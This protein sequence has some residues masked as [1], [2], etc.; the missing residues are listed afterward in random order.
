MA[1][2]PTGAMPLPEPGQ[3]VSRH[4]PAQSDGSR[5]AEKMADFPARHAGGHD[6]GI[7]KTGFFG[8]GATALQHGDIVPITAQLIGRGDADDAGAN[9]C[10]LHESLYSCKPCGTDRGEAQLCPQLIRCNWP[11]ALVQHARVATIFVVFVRSAARC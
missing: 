11:L 10:N 5:A 2:K 6:A 1:V 8:C 4:W 3:L 7:G 9:N